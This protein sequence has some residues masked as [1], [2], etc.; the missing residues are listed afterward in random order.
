MH[1]VLIG[2]VSYAVPCMIAFLLYARTDGKPAV[3]HIIG[4]NAFAQAVHDVAAHNPYEVVEHVT[5]LQGI[6]KK[7]KVGILLKNR[8]KKWNDIE[9]TMRLHFRKFDVEDVSAGAMFEELAK[10]KRLST[11]KSKDK[12]D[13]PHKC[14]HIHREGESCAKNNNCTYPNCPK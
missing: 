12:G 11:R 7:G 13:S 1:I 8:H 6:L 14:K 5:D 3:V 10:R 9:D 2:P 4:G